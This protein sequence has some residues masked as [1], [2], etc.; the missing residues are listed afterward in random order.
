MPFIKKPTFSD[1]LSILSPKVKM[2]RNELCWCNSGAKWKKCHNLRASQKPDTVT[3]LLHEFDSQKK[4]GLC[5]H[6]D[7][8]T[9]CDKKIVRAHTIQKSG[10]LAVIAENGHVYSGRNSRPS[11]GSQTLSD[12]LTLIGVTNASTFKGFCSRHDNET[13]RPA[14][15]ASVIT[16]EVAFLMSYRALAYEVYEKMIAVPTMEALRNRIDRGLNFEE[17]SRAQTEFDLGLQGFRAGLNEHQWHKA[18]YEKLLVG[19]WE[20]KFHGFIIEL[21]GIMPIV[22]SGTFFPEFDFLGNKLQSINSE[23]GT[24][25]LMAFNIVV[26]ARKTVAVFG[27]DKDPTGA[28]RKFIN[29]IKNIINIKISDAILRFCFEICDNIFVRPSWWLELDLDKRKD[30]L[31]RLRENTPGSHLSSGLIVGANRYVS[32]SMTGIFK[33]L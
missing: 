14:D 12:D 21:D 26:I 22:S 27:W 24:L 2:G 11:K 23:I 19:S 9:E 4:F 30:L 25:S 3:R 1:Q 28:N 5:L 17:Q 18:A 13:F 10:S 20:T 8:P 16:K 33:S 15:T 31:N 6:P 7:A 29:S 32:D